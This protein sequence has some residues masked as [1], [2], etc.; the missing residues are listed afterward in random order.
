M[1]LA[2][3]KKLDGSVR[4]QFKKKLEAHLITPRVPAAARSGMPDCDK[5]KPRA[6]G[7]RLV[8]RVD[9]GE[10]RVTVISRSAC[11]KS[12]RPTPGR[13]PAWTTHLGT[14]RRLEKPLSR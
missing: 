8:H 2:E 13:K 11:G 9:D 3:W 7:H 4:A 14:D 12:S 6:A 10:V 1:A 5:I